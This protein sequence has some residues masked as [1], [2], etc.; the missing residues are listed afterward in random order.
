MTSEKAPL[1]RLF[2]LTRTSLCLDKNKEMVVC[3]LL[4]NY[5]LLGP[6]SNAAGINGSRHHCVQRRLSVGPRVDHVQTQI[7]KIPTIARDHTQAMLR[8]GCTQKTV[9]G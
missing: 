4:L 8:G 7:C 1:R 5:S 3:S 6:N 9:N 2:G